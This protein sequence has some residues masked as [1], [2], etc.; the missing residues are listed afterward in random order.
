M[1][2]PTA[3]G[4]VLRVPPA[5][6]AEAA[7]HF[8]AS[9]AFH[10]D[11]S[12]VAASLEAGGDPG[13]VVVD[14]RSTGAWDQGHVPGALHLPTA[15]VPERAEWLLDKDVP[16][17]TYCWGP[18]CNGATRAALAL[19]ELG[20]RVKEMLGGFEYWVREGFA[21]ESRQGRERS[22]PDPLTAPTGVGDCGC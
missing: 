17:V 11:A 14:S 2:L 12:D 19:A 7:A 21:Y 15:L 6:P 3:A 22:D 20:Y 4:P 13:F 5:P 16:V 10:V 1:T 9:L 8:R 18:G